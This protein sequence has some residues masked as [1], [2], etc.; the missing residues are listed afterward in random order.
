MQLA[1][2]EEQEELE[3]AQLQLQKAVLAA[4]VLQIIHLGVQQLQLVKIL[5]ELIIMLV[6]VAVDIIAQAAQ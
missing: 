1:V 6:A 5:E 3:A 4:L 2:A